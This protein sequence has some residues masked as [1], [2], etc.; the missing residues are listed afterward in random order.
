MPVEPPRLTGH[1]EEN[2]ARRHTATAQLEHHPPPERRSPGAEMLSTTRRTPLTPP[3]VAGLCSPMAQDRL[4][5]LSA[6]TRHRTMVAKANSQER[7]VAT[8]AG[9]P[10]AAE[11][12]GQ[13]PKALRLS[14]PR[15]RA[16][17]LIARRYLA[18]VQHRAAESGERASRGREGRLSR[19]CPPRATGAARSTASAA[20]PQAIHPPLGN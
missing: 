16:G 11:R 10:W 3:R 19:T 17:E 15:P 14:L 4:K 13:R 9:V 20:T 2:D 8:S 5:P 6:Q 18:P 1:G 7:N 12:A